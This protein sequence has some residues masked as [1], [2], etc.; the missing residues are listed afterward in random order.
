MLRWFGM[1]PDQLSNPSYREGLSGT[2]YNRDMNIDP[3]TDVQPTDDVVVPAQ[4]VPP[5]APLQPT[6][7]VP[8][9]DVAQPTDDTIAPT[10][11]LIDG[12]VENTDPLQ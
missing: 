9:W 7:I 1:D 2:D 3:T 6:D 4:E 11:D 12:D 8:E 5:T 10:T